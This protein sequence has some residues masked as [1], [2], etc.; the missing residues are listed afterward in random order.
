ERLAEG[1]ERVVAVA[2]AHRLTAR[3]HPH[4]STIVERPEQVE[5]ILGRTRINFCPDTAHLAAAGGDAAELIRR[6]RDRIVYVHLKDFTAEPFAFLPL[7]KGDLD[8]EAMLVELEAAGY[9]GWITVELDEFAGA[10]VDAARESRQY[11][12]SLLART[13]PR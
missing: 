2:E 10:P 6:Y 12:D 8:F 13:G 4:L 3:Y 5:K 11:L 7:G 9:Y 1:L